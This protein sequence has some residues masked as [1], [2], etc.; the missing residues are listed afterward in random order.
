MAK[1]YSLTKIIFITIIL[2]AF[3]AATLFAQ[4]AKPKGT[5][6]KSTTGAA[7][8]TAT[9]GA[10][11]TKN[12]KARGIIAA[13]M[14]CTVKVNGSAKAINAKAYAPSVIMLTYGVNNIEAVSADKKT[15]ATFRTT[16]NVTDTTRQLIEISFFD[17]SKFLDYVKEGRKD[18][19]ELAIKK[20]PD[21]VTNEGQILQSSPLQIAITYSQPDIVK[22]FVDKGA[23]FT[24]PDNIY[25]MHKAT[26]FASS[27]KEKDKDF[28]PD[29]AIVDFFLT[30]G[31][32]ITDKDDAGNTLL[33]AACRG[34]K[35][36]LVDYYLSKGLDINAKNE[37][38]D[39]PLKIAEDKG[40]VSIINFLIE[41]GAIQEKVEEPKDDDT[42][43]PAKTDDK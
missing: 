3:Q 26:L 24:K 4:T 5:A 2:L 7:K 37:A 10:A 19:V 29:R 36:D 34:G 42:A 30:K 23:S 1:I 25:P 20:D 18:M 13:D 9:K 31:C 38:G 6:T 43:E 14:D 39:T 12:I 15:P 16:V 21:L 33:H 22:L 17:A 32:K 8:T 28:A 41:K 35:L 11:T 27:I 40:A